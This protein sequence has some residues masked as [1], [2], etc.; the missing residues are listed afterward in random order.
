MRF[1][2][3][4]IAAILPVFASAETIVVET[5]P[6]SVV[7]YPVGAMVTR[8][9]DVEIPAGHSELILPDLPGNDDNLLP[10]MDISVGS[11][12]LLSTK[13]RHGKLPP[14][15]LA[16]L[17]AL[18]AAKIQVKEIEAAILL[19]QDEI[20]RV[21]LPKTS[22]ASKITFL[23]SLTQSQFLPE[24]IADLR[25]L[26]NLVESE[27]LKA[28]QITAD[29]DRSLRSL[30]DAL[31][32]LEEKRVDAEQLVGALEP[33][34]EHRIEV[35]LDLFS[36][37]PQTIRASIQY[38]SAGEWSPAYA[39]YL[40]ADVNKLSIQRHLDVIN[41]SNEA[42]RDV[43]LVVSTAT[44]FDRSQVTDVWSRRRRIQDPKPAPSQVNQQLNSVGVSISLDEPIVEAPVIIE[45]T[46]QAHFGANVSYVLNELVTVLPTHETT[47]LSLG[48]AEFDAHVFARANPRNDETAFLVAEVENTSDE[49]F[50]E[51][52]NSLFFLDGELVAVGRF[53]QIPAG[54]T[55][56]LPFGPL[57]DLRL[58]FVNKNVLEGDKGV[59]SRMNTRSEFSEWTIRNLGDKSYDVFVRSGVPYSEQ[60]DL[61]IEWN[62]STPPETVDVDDKKGVHEWFVNMTPKDK[63]TVTI[64]VQMSWPLDKVLR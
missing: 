51:T 18:A 29:I 58:E 33:V 36:D 63:K 32:E 38:V 48:T 56:E 26:M 60:D 49:P 40:D 52:G 28:T 37:A 61:T 34:T 11:A 55:V 30:N 22:L 46:A 41:R 4:F 44:P 2:L 54:E 59:I 39:S 5:K 17:P 10:I 15:D 62:A 27:T 35:I 20:A 16:D 7:L 64:D 31:E 43:T 42:W 12:R 6:T 23:K 45:E 3:I 8:A 14:R 53:P 1:C 57:E 50:L 21:E 9:F 47:R 13:I 25:E 24:N 19:K